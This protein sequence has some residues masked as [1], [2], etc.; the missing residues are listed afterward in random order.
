[1]SSSN[2]RIWIMR[3]ANVCAALSCAA[4]FSVGAGAAP[5]TVETFDNGWYSQNNNSSGDLTAGVSNINVGWN[6]V[7]G[8]TYRNWLAFDLS[9]LAGQNITSA[10]LTFYGNNGTYD[11]P[12]IETLGLFDYN[13]SINALLGSQSGVGIYNDLGTGTSFGQS[14]VAS[15]LGMFSI[16]LTAEAVNALNA[17][18]GNTTDQRFVIGGSLLSIAALHDGSNWYG[19]GQL[20]RITGPT[21]ALDHAAYL[22]METSPVPVPAALP[23]FASSL[24]GGFFAARRKRRKQS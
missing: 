20:F 10:T 9:A 6:Q 12:K 21:S 7:T 17:A 5:V 23:L 13:G 11:S 1:M 4:L 24:F 2:K 15:P 19:D 16:T 14:A 22:S 18:A 3:I 8:A